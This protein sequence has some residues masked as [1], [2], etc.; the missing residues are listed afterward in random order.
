LSAEHRAI[1]LKTETMVM[2]DQDPGRDP[3]M[4]VIGTIAIVSPVGNYKEAAAQAQ[5]DIGYV[6]S[7]NANSRGLASFMVYELLDGHNVLLQNGDWATVFGA[8]GFANLDQP[9]GVIKAYLRH[10][11]AAIAEN[12][13]AVEPFEPT[14]QAGYTTLA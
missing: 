13:V 11:G 6:P 8:S 4:S 14:S 7:P 3:F 5:K 9:D 2:D 1:V 10:I 12:A